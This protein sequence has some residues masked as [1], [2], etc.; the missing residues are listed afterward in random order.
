MKKTGLFLPVFF[1]LVLVARFIY[2]LVYT[3]TE[4]LY[5]DMLRHHATGKTFFD[6]GFDNAISFKL[7][8]LYMW[9]LVT[10]DK[11]WFANTL[12]GLQCFAMPICWFLLVKELTQSNKTALRLSTIIGLIPQGLTIYSFF[13][14]ET[15][16]LIL[17]PLSLWAGIKF[18]RLPTLGSFTLATVIGLATFFVRGTVFPVTVGLLVIMMFRVPNKAVAFLIAVLLYVATFTLGALHTR[19][20]INVYAPN[21]FSLPTQIY[22]YSGSKEYRTNIDGTYFF[23]GSPTFLASPFSPFYEYKSFRRDNRFNIIIDT[24]DGTKDWQRILDNLKSRNGSAGYLWKMFKENTIFY[25]FSRSWPN[26]RGDVPIMK[27]S[28]HFRYIWPPLILL[29]TF[30]IPIYLYRRF[31]TFYSTVFTT[32]HTS[33][34]FT[35]SHTTS[36]SL[37]P[38]DLTAEDYI[39]KIICVIQH[40]TAVDIFLAIT[41]LFNLSFFLGFTQ[42][43]MEGRYRL[44][45]EP[46][47]V[48]AIYLLACKH[49]KRLKGVF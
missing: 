27:Y 8:Q 12:N 15:L 34:P 48:I 22:A 47:I 44:P 36:P 41:W 29:I 17:L 39:Q 37:S 49:G 18:L 14:P 45:I 46:M 23:W 20:A 10:V 40:A 32:S 3:P 1:G 21:G 19:K 13:M 9:I 24:A 30:W 11:L 31:V 42:G 26:D 2:P 35:A 38:P 33:Q 28:V 6:P 7:H 16:L 5:S 25:M 4:F 43:I